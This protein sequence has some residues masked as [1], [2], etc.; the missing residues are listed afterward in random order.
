MG[1]DERDREL[2]GA[3]LALAVHHVVSDSALFLIWERRR[4]CHVDNGRP[5]PSPVAG[6]LH[7]GNSIDTRKDRDLQTDLERFLSG[8]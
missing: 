5:D 1:H 4:P 2:S 7:T 6:P 3:A 8:K